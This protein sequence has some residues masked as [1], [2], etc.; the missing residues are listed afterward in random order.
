[1][2]TRSITR[3][4]EEH[5][6]LNTNK[7]LIPTRDINPNIYPNIYSKITEPKYDVNIDF[8]GASSAWLSNKK[9]MGNGFYKYVCEHK[10]NNGTNCIRKPIAG[11]NCCHSHS[12][13]HNII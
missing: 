4:L 5:R 8:D 9:L 1:M 10:N 6:N 12:H 2:K 3:N 13:S 11:T 7:T